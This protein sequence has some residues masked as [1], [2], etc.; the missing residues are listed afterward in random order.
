MKAYPYIHKH[1]TTGNTTMAEGADLR[2]L[3]AGIAMQKLMGSADVDDCCQSA[4]AWADAMMKA[5][6]VK[7]EHS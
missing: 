5:R 7:N 4:Y 3:F 2:D 6:E 1:P